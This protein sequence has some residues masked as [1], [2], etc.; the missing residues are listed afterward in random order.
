MQSF[1]HQSLGFSP[2]VRD[3]PSHSSLK[4]IRLGPHGRQQVALETWIPFSIAVIWR[5]ST[6]QLA[7]SVLYA[8]EKH[9]MCFWCEGKHKPVCQCWKW[10]KPGHHPRTAPLTTSAR[11]SSCNAEVEGKVKETCISPS[12]GERGGRKGS[13]QQRIKYLSNGLMS[14]CAH[15]A[16]WTM[17]SVGKNATFSGKAGRALWSLFFSYFLWFV[18][19]F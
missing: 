12:L 13:T 18:L 7:L 4:K 2:G 5:Y 11:T 8:V 10:P 19:S 6:L 3:R 14:C 15:A 16:S 17:V 9:A 1:E